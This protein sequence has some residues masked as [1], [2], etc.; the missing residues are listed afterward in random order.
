[1]FRKGGCGFSCAEDIQDLPER[2]P[3]QPTVGDPALAAELD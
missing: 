1:M 2:G 3:V